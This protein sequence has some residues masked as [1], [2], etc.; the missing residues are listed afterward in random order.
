MKRLFKER[1]ETFHSPLTVFFTFKH[2]LTVAV[3]GEQKLKIADSLLRSRLIDENL[4]GKEC[5]QYILRVHNSTQMFF[6]YLKS[7]C[8]QHYDFMVQFLM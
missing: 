4:L 6:Y 5:I 8:C 3:G 1:S 7:R 2:S